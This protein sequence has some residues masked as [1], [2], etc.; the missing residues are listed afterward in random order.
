[1]GNEDT[2]SGWPRA[3]PGERGYYSFPAGPDGEIGRRGGLKI[4]CPMGVQVRVLLRARGPAYGRV[5]LQFALRTAAG[6]RYVKPLEFALQTPRGLRAGPSAV[7]SA[8]CAVHDC[9]QV[10]LIPPGCRWIAA[11]GRFAGVVSR[12]GEG[13]SPAPGTRTRLRAGPSA[14][15]S[16]NCGRGEICGADHVG[17]C[18]ANSTEV[19]GPSAVR[20][21]N[22][23]IW[24]AT[25]VIGSAGR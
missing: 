10:G 7:R 18:F 5:R 1:M 23:V 16:A 9:R 6:E 15:R 3:S 22:C 13:S 4:R 2:R 25:D 21:A 20:F 17:V 8:N 12:W 19:A 24:A 14:V 11:G